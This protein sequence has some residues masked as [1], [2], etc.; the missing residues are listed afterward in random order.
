MWGIGMEGKEGKV[1]MLV[2]CKIKEPNLHTYTTSWFFCCA[3]FPPPHFAN[4]LGHHWNWLA[5]LEKVY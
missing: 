1:T 4:N 3:L 5:E 2:V